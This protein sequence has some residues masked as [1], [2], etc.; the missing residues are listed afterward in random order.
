AQASRNVDAVFVTISTDYVFDGEKG[1]FYTQLDQPNPKSVYGAMK[2][3]GEQQAQL[4]YARSIVVRSG[5]IFGPGG[6]NFLSTVADRLRREESVGAIADAWGTPTYAAHLASRLRELVLLD[7]AGIY[8]V[9]NSG[10]GAAY[11]EF[12]RAVALELGKDQAMV[13]SVLSSTLDRPAP[14][15]RNSRLK[16]LIS[17]ERGLRPLP[18]WGEGVRE[19]LSLERSSRTTR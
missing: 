2:L 3:A 11:D 10:E 9:V 14:R 19:F 5:F 7:L 13:Q 4:A 15:P 18:P 16:C 17:E 8:H 6:R 12:A 1:G